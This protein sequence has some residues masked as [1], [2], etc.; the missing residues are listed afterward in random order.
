MLILIFVHDTNKNLN[1]CVSCQIFR[2]LRGTQAYLK[3]Y[4]LLILSQWCTSIIN[5]DSSYGWKTVGTQISWLHSQLI[6]VYNVLKN[7]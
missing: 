6:W 3:L 5:I 1:K 4:E 7:K 2:I